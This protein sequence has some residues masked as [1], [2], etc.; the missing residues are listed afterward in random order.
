VYVPRPALPKGCV[1]APIVRPIPF[2]KLKLL[3]LSDLWGSCWTHYNGR[4]TYCPGPAHCE[5]FD[6]KS[7]VCNRRWS[8]WL[9][10]VQWHPQRRCVLALTPGMADIL[11][12]WREQGKL[13]RGFVL[14]CERTDARSNAP[15]GLWREEPSRCPG[16][17]PSPST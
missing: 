6:P 8:G 14:G 11:W 2:V 3:P 9:P 12:G 7:N 15:V 13:L 10:C 1:F 4:T 16:A 17:S 5:C